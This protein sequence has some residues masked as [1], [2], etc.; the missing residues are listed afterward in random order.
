MN[1]NLGT[2]EEYFDEPDDFFEKVGKGVLRSWV[3]NGKKNNLELVNS[4]PL[5]KLLYYL[6]LSSQE[7]P[8]GWE[9]DFQSVTDLLSPI[10]FAIYGKKITNFLLKNRPTTTVKMDPKNRHKQIK[11]KQSKRRSITPKSPQ[12][13]KHFP[14]WLPTLEDSD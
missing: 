5:Q 8:I 14:E 2:I 6:S 10:D 12:R 11:R 1:S 4:A 13:N 9:H 7:L 3:E